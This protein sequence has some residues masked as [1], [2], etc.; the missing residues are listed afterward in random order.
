MTVAPPLIGLPPAKYI[1]LLCPVPSNLFPHLLL[2]CPYNMPFEGYQPKI[3]RGNPS[4]YF[5]HSFS[6]HLDVMTLVSVR[7]P[8]VSST[9]TRHG[10]KEDG[11]LY[12]IRKYHVQIKRESA[13]PI[14]DIM[15]KCRLCDSDALRH[16]LMPIQSFLHVHERSFYTVSEYAFM[17]LATM[18]PSLKKNGYM[19][20]HDDVWSI[21]KQVFM[22]LHLFALAQNSTNNLG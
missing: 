22:T 14:E 7:I 1:P 20:C 17:T 2:F 4:D 6:S 5:E 13:H 16:L 8:K 10:T 18:L 15:R 11:N 19:L 9:S 21:F 12:G 3:T